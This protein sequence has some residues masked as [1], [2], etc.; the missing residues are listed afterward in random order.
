VA[1]DFRTQ[2]KEN[3]VD[4]VTTTPTFSWD[5]VDKD[6]SGQSAF[7]LQ[8][9]TDSN[10]SSLAWDTG[11][12]NAAATSVAY[13]STPGP[14]VGPLPLSHAGG[15]YF[16][17][18]QVS[19]GISFSAM[20]SVDA[21]DA[22]S[23]GFFSINTVPGDPTLT[24]PA[25]GAYAGPIEVT[26]LPASPEDADGDEVYYVVEA[27]ASFSSNKGWSQIAGPLPS[28]ATS[29]T[30]DVSS[31]KSGDDYAV[32]VIAT[33]QYSQSNPGNGG[34]SERLTILNHAPAMP[35]LVRPFAGA[36]ASVSTLV[37][38]VEADPPDVDGDSVTYTLEMTRDFS[39]AEP[40]WE[41]IGLFPAGTSKYSL[42]VDGFDDGVHYNVRVKATDEHGASSGYSY[43][44]EFTVSNSLM[45]QDFQR[46]NGELYIGTSDGRV[47]KAS[48]P[49]WQVDE[50]W[51][52]GSGTA[53][54]EEFMAGNPVVQVKDGKLVIS[55][56]AGSTY[57]LRQQK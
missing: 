35:D 48:D 47:Y 20:P 17:R 51:A 4:V 53:S 41:R 13:G 6:G 50:N 56:P 31:V 38:W 12:V 21:G 14:L 54:F 8:V 43:S 36:V 19:D 46:V 39:V 55:A 24:A 28:P 49:F 37:E 18:V 22:G 32:R 2:G 9:A 7:R 45:A 34:T 57:L 10:F 16:A 23:M 3:P 27:T 25:G 15:T 11:V 30:W 29:F 40:T 33:D 26:W 5:F 52:S 42:R 1:S 44:G